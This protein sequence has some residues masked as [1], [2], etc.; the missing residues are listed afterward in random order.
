MHKTE[1]TQRRE[2]ERKTEIE[3]RTETKTF[4]HDAAR[5]QQVKQERERERNALTPHCIWLDY[6]EKSL[7]DSQQR[8]I[9]QHDTPFFDLDSNI[10]I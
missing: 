10:C 8:I 3:T 6:S 2:R 7:A 9:R 4:F 1:T 5:F